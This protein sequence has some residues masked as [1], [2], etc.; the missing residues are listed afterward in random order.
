M[1]INISALEEQLQSIISEYQEQAKL[2]DRHIFVIGCSTSEVIGQK[3]GTAGAIDV[4]GFIFQQLLEYKEEAGVELAFQC[5]EHLNRALVVERKLQE[6]KNLS[7][8]SVIPVRQAGGA[9]AA[10]AYQHMKDPVVVE[11]ITADGGIDIGDTLIGMHIKHVAVP[12][13]V[14]HKQLGEAHV[15]LAKTRPKLIGG[16][17]AVYEKTQDNESC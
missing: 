14:S 8:V 12:I 13:R 7:E 17:R 9:M 3:I 4:A 2:T 16:Q 10:Y 1:D 15:T 6:E 11:H 5:C